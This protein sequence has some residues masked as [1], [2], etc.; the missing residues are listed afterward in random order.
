MAQILGLPLASVGRIET[1]PLGAYTA[2]DRVTPETVGEYT[3]LVC[4]RRMVED[5]AHQMAQVRPAPFF[6]AFFIACVL[7]RALLSRAPVPPHS[8]RDCAC[9]RRCSSP[10][11][12]VSSACTQVR[13]GF[14][15]LVS[16]AALENV[17]SAKELE[18]VLVGSPDVDID[19]WR[20]HSVAKG[21]G[22]TSPQV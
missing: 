1:A 10:I 21:F 3:E 14:E 4:H 15:E 11:L 20:H 13:Y 18:K 5:V 12:A 19:D 6:S 2:S 16:R 7:L 17:V 9:G 8:M 22:P